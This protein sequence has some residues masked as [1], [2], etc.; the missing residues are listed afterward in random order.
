MANGFKTHPKSLAEQ[1][2]IVVQLF[3]RLQEGPIRQ[4]QS[5]SEII[6]EANAGKSNG[7]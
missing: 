4:Y 6:G 5:A 7:F 1:I 2:N 3:G